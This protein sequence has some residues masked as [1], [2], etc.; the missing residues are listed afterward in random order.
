MA[1]YPLTIFTAKSPRTISPQ[2]TIKQL[3]E[4]SNEQYLVLL[5]KDCEIESLKQ[6][7]EILNELVELK[8]KK[9]AIHEKHI[10]KLNDLIRNR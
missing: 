10:G 6:H 7:I 1:K 8:D 4:K 5:D 3:E 9:I 2:E